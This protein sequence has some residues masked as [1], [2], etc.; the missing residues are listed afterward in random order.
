MPI[1]HEEIR[2]IARLARLELNEK[3]TEKFSHQLSA[4]LDHAKM[5]DEVD[6][7]GVEPIAQIT[8]LTSV[9]FADQPKKEEEIKDYL[10]QSPQPIQ[11]RMIKVKSVF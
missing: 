2:R 1:S 4:I 11:D 6:T 8:G 3:E 7:E 5:L 9:L 10:T